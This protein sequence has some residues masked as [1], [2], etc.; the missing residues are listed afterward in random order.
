VTHQCSIRIE[1]RCL[2]LQAGNAPLDLWDLLHPLHTMDKEIPQTVTADP[3]TVT[4]QGTD[5]DC[6]E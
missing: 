3:P 6:T 5:C 1:L 4:A 2:R